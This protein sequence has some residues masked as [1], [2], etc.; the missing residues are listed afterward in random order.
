VLWAATPA[1]ATSALRAP[2]NAPIAEPPPETISSAIDSLAAD[3]A[4]ILVSSRTAANILSKVSAIRAS[5]AAAVRKGIIQLSKSAVVGERRIG[6]ATYCLSVRGILAP[7]SSTFSCS[8]VETFKLV[9]PLSREAIALDGTTPIKC[10]ECYLRYQRA[11]LLCDPLYDAGQSSAALK[12]VNAVIADWKLCLSKCSGQPRPTP[13]A[14]AELPGLATGSAPQRPSNQDRVNLDVESS[15]RP[16][17]Q[18]AHGKWLADALAIDFVEL[19]GV[20]G[21]LRNAPTRALPSSRRLFKPRAQYGLLC[22]HCQ[23]QRS[24]V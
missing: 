10:N 1:N 7:T 22:G 5:A 4:A 23:V 12:C 8:N 3:G 13:D 11:L 16:L 24:G 6:G 2:G 15:E 9:P 18:R 21:F 20:N 19:F 14:E 17:S